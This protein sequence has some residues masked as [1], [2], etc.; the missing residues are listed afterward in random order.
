MIQTLKIK[1]M[2]KQIKQI[3]LTVFVFAL[4]CIGA[5][6]IIAQ[7]ADDG[8]ILA[9]EKYQFAPFEKVQGLE[10]IYSKKE[11]EEA[12]NDSAFEMERLIYS[13]DG[14][15]VVGYLYKPKNTENKKYPAIIF[16]RG[17]Y[18]RGNIGYELAPF[19]RRLALE[20]FVVIAPLYR[21]SDGADGKDEVGGGDVK[22][23]MNLL[24][25]AKSLDFIETKNLFL[26]GESRGGMMTFQAVRNNFPANA[27]ATFGA[28]TDFE[29]LIT[30]SPKLYQPLIKAIWTDFEA[31]KDEIIKTRSALQWADKINV[32]LLLMHGGSD[33]SVDPLQ[34]LNFAQ[35]LQK[36]GKSYELMIYNGDNHILSKNQKDRDA[37]AIAWFK[38]HL[39]Q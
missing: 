14:L 32:P 25:L 35:T 36:L 2:K 17:G 37:K 15:S 38:K 11:Y 16:N 39:E 7:N 30:A 9:R 28:F 22:D 10:K 26:Y 12:V 8:K 1:M 24:P 19:F 20:G 23:L 33:Q 29:A 34:T 6:I 13:S 27:A 18:I 3:F 31:R 5:S 4:N 21:A